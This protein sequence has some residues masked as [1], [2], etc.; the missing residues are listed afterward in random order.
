MR[1]K[2]LKMK[3]K[4]SAI[5]GIV[6][7]AAGLLAVAP[8]LAMPPT[9]KPGNHGKSDDR[10]HPLGIKQREMHEKALE[11]KLNGKAYGKTHEVAR[12]Q[13]VELERQ[14]EDSVWTVLG[15]FSNFPHNSIAEPDR[16]FDNTTIWTPDFS[17]D[18]YMDMI[19]SEEPGSNSMRNFYIEQSS[20]RYTV[21]GDVTDWVAVPGVACDYDDGD[22]GPGGALSV[23]Q[24]LIDS[25]DGWYDAQIATGKTPAEIDAYLSDFD[26]W[27]RYDYDADGN[28]D[29][30]DG[31][32]DHMQFVHAGEGNE[33][34]GGALGDCAIWSHSWYTY[35][36]LDVGPDFNHAGGVQIGNSDYW[37]GNYTIQPENGGVGVF[38]HEYAHDLGLPDL[39]DY[40]G[41]N[42]TGFWT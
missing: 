38:A 10:P 1:N 35:Y 4:I 5:L 17:R 16:D 26:V 37:I 7:L 31:Y 6:T 32:I 21:Y 14:G 41:E 11:A 27:D 33:A 8:T 30:P 3:H 29:E 22:P 9:D 39:Y 42:S 40:T 34:G 28:F 19:F 24:F 2:P 15:E 36:W 25:L 18:Y 20:N 23:W 12:G 13:F